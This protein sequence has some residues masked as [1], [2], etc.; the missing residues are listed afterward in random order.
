MVHDYIL[1]DL[2]LTAQK[3][4]SRLTPH[5]VCDLGLAQH[6]LAILATTFG[7]AIL[8]SKANMLQ[9]HFTKFISSYIYTYI[10]T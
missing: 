10:Y 2:L 7:I 6:L 1:I 5:V 9:T 4:K 3:H 8:C